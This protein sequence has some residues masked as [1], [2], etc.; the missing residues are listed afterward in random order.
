MKELFATGIE[1]EIRIRLKNKIYQATNKFEQE[2][3]DLNVNKPSYLF[4]NSNNII[5]KIFRKLYFLLVIKKLLN[6]EIIPG[7]K[8]NPYILDKFY[9]YVS[10]ENIISK[11]YKQNLNLI[12]D[13]NRFNYIF[14]QEYL[15]YYYPLLIADININYSNSQ[16]VSKLLKKIYAIKND[17]DKLLKTSNLKSKIMGHLKK[18][19]ISNLH[20]K[21]FKLLVSNKIAEYSI[22][23]FNEKYRNYL[24]II[25]N[26]YYNENVICNNK[27]RISEITNKTRKEQKNNND[28]S[29]FNFKLISDNDFKIMNMMLNN[30]D[31]ALTSDWSD[32]T[33]VSEFKTIK[34]KNVSLNKNLEDLILYEETVFKVLEAD[35]SIKYLTDNYGPL[36]YHHTGSINK[37]VEIVKINSNK[38]KLTFDLSV[39][40]LDY[41]GSYHLWLT[42][43]YQIKTPSKDFVESNIFLGNLLQMIE[44]LILSNYGSPH[45]K[46]MGNSKTHVRSSLR[47]FINPYGAVGSSDLTLLRGDDLTH[48]FDF[49]LKKENVLKYKSLYINKYLNV[50]DNNN[51]IVKNYKGL[52][53]REATSK[54]LLPFPITK[55]KFNN[56]MYNIKNYLEIVLEKSNIDIYKDTVFKF[57]PIIGAD[58]RVKDWGKNYNKPLKKKIS[59]VYVLDGKKIKEQYFDNTK[60]IV[61]D[62][63]KKVIDNVKSKKYLSNRMGLEFRIFDHFSPSTMNEILPII[64][65]FMIHSYSNFKILKGQDMI[66]NKQIYHNVVADVIMNGYEAKFKTQYIKYIEKI[67]NI[68]LDKRSY[69]SVE[70]L[71]E[72]RDKLYNKYKNEKLLNRLYN[73]KRAL[74]IMS[75][76]RRVWMENLKEMLETNKYLFEKFG[77]LNEGMKKKDI[78]KILGK[79]WE[80]NAD[81]VLDYLRNN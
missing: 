18:K 74:P 43:P 73:F 26:L 16:E 62:D 66:I 35:S 41:T 10:I 23:V 42:L 45:P 30:D 39:I 53:T 46:S 69:L 65:L 44:P 51:K 4:I 9:R 14:N 57:D 79:E 15:N 49:Y 32:K 56:K 22:N 75:M 47:Q 28:F 38:N 54:N 7:V 3:L 21:L 71:T 33:D 48:I 80:S 59:K 78:I 31:P 64:A 6:N 68:K 12:I 20:S 77:K 25:I 81:K 52:E 40:P 8:N 1:H 50:Y 34:Y 27:F 13:K 24:T 63:R 67:L 58:I 11:K 61:I 72:I 37:S 70:L 55:Q 76:S 17:L 36:T 2:I 60:R 19:E 5:N 29:N